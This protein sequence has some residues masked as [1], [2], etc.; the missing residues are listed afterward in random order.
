[1]KPQKTSGFGTA[2]HI[3]ETEEAFLLKG[4]NFT[5]C[6]DRRT[7]LFSGLRFEGC[8]F[9]E[10]PMELNIWRAPTD[11]DMYIK[12]EWKRA[13][14]DRAYVR[15]YNSESRQTG[16]GAKIRSRMSIGAATVQPMMWI[17]S[18]W[19]VGAEGGLEAAFSI[20]RNMEFPELPRFGIRMFLPRELNQVS[21][22]GMGPYESYRDKH[23]ASVHG[24][25]QA[26]VWKL[27]EDYLRPQENGSHMD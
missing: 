7:G 27:H 9:L 21:Y 6:F 5:Y 20:K 26:P 11:N 22:Y 4:E 1:M 25:Y 16:S 19:Q 23:Q 10:R 17:E 15:A 14:Y 13:Q 8:D 12:E 3:T 24:L 18:V 2:I